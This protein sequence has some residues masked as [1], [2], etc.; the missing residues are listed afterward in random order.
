[1]LGFCPGYFDPLSLTFFTFFPG[2][3]YANSNASRN[4]GLLA[5]SC[6]M[7]SRRALSASVTPNLRSCG[8]NYKGLAYVV[9]V[10]GLPCLQRNLSQFLQKKYKSLNR[11][12]SRPD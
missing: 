8:V 9:P 5:N 6:R 12:I 10:M 1:M 3:G 11:P 2:L 7:G 4:L